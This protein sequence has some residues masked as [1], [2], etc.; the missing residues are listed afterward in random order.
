M[1]FHVEY[2]REEGKAASWVTQHKKKEEQK[3]KAAKLTNDRNN[4]Q[5][6]ENK[7]N[8]G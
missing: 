7:S 3:W 5:W 6:A 2:E 8:F 1:T 4:K